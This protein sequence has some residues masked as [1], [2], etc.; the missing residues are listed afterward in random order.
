MEERI[1]IYIPPELVWEF[2]TAHKKELQTEMVCV[3]E[4]T[5]TGVQ[6]FLSENKDFA[7]LTVVDSEGFALYTGYGTSDCDAQ[8]E[9]ETLG[10]KYVLPGAEKPAANGDVSED[11]EEEYL[12]DDELDALLCRKDEVDMAFA[13]F[14]AVLLDNENILDE[15]P[16]EEIEYHVQSIVDDFVGEGR[17]VRYPLIEEG[18]TKDYYTEYQSL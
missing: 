14:L 3:M 16:L 17:M 8:N 10:A 12:T 9:V 13:D 7:E 15:I 6:M 18:E 5:E 1:K 11:G 2:Y 4:N